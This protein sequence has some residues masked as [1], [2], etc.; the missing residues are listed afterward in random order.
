MKK[1]LLSTI[2]LVALILVKGENATSGESEGHSSWGQGDRGRWSATKGVASH[3]GDSCEPFEEWMPLQ[4]FYQFPPDI[5]S[6]STTARQLQGKV[7]HRLTRRC[8]VSQLRNQKIARAWFSRASRGRSYCC[9][10]CTARRL[11][12]R[13]SV[14]S[15]IFG[16]FNESGES[17]DGPP[18][19][20]IFAGAGFI[21]IAPDYLGLGDSTVPRHR[22]F[23]A[24]TEASSTA[25]LLVASRRVLASLLV[26][27]NDELFIFGFSQ[28]GHAAL[29]LHRELQNGHV[30]VTGHGYC[31]RRVRR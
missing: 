2:A 8:R 6:L 13:C 28:G 18:S 24:A 20:S 10:Y 16:Q 29:A 27:Q 30:D 9:I 17:F 26:E 5:P 11:V 31:R 12:L 15:N 23:H 4:D 22:Y 25:D 3:R 1:T 14:E 21:Y 19:N 7:L